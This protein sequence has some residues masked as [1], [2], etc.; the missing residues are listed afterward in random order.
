MLSSVVIAIHSN[1]ICILLIA[2]VVRYIMQDAA[3]AE[4]TFQS[5]FIS[6]DAG[7]DV[8]DPDQ[9]FL[10]NIY[11]RSNCRGPKPK[12]VGRLVY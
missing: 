8:Y 11:S 3:A 7:R 10:V 2:S 5:Q 4:T 1:I 6:I 9:L 12:W